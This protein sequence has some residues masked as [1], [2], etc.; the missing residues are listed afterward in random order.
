MEKPTMIDLNNNKQ[1][2]ALTNSAATKGAE[3]NLKEIISEALG[4]FSEKFFEDFQASQGMEKKMKALLYVFFAKAGGVKSPI[5]VDEQFTS[6]RKEILPEFQVYSFVG[7]F[8]QP[9]LK[10]TRTELFREVCNFIKKTFED[11]HIRLLHTESQLVKE[12]QKHLSIEDIDPQSPAYYNWFVVSEAL[13]VLKF[14]QKGIN[15]DKPVLM[16]REGFQALM[17][18]LDAAYPEEDYTIPFVEGYLPQGGHTFDLDVRVAEPNNFRYF[19]E[20]MG[21]NDLSLIAEVFSKLNPKEKAKPIELKK[22][23]IHSG[24]VLVFDEDEKDKAISLIPDGYNDYIVKMPAGD[25]LQ[26][27]QVVTAANQSGMIPPQDMVSL[28]SVGALC[29][30]ILTYGTTTVGCRTKYDSKRNSSRDNKGF[31]HLGLD[32]FEVIKRILDK[33]DTVYEQ[34]SGSHRDDV[35]AFYFNDVLNWFPNP[36]FKED[37]GKL[38]FLDAVGEDGDLSKLNAYRAQ[39]GE[40]GTSWKYQ[41]TGVNKTQTVQ[42]LLNRGYIL[43]T[44]N[45]TALSSDILMV[46]GEDLTEDECSLLLDLLDKKGIKHI[47]SRVCG[48]QDVKAWKEEMVNY[49]G[50]LENL[51]K[52]VARHH[53]DDLVFLMSNKG[54]NKAID[55]LRNLFALVESPHAEVTS[56]LGWQFPKSKVEGNTGIAIG[57]IKTH[58]FTGIGDGTSLWMPNNKGEKQPI[59][60]IGD[61]E[62]RHDFS[63]PEEEYEADIPLIEVVQPRFAP[64]GEEEKD[65]ELNLLYNFDFDL[66]SKTAVGVEVS[67]GDT[68][69]HVCTEEVDYT[70]SSSQNGYLTQIKAYK[71]EDKGSPRFRV[72]AYYHTIETAFKG[73]GPLKMTLLDVNW[74]GRQNLLKLNHNREDITGQFV[75][76]GQCLK[77]TDIAYNRLL[78]FGCTLANGL[79]NY[80]NLSNSAKNIIKQMK[81]LAEEYNSK[82]GYEGIDNRVVVDPKGIINN[83]HKPLLD[84]VDKTFGGSIWFTPEIHHEHI[85]ALETTFRA[86]KDEKECVVVQDPQTSVPEVANKKDL[87]VL[88]NKE[89]P[90]EKS[91]VVAFYD[92]GGKR[93]YATRVYAYYGV[94][95]TPEFCLPTGIEKSTVKDAVGD[96]SLTPSVIRNLPE[97]LAEEMTFDSKRK[98]QVF[99]L[100]SA[101]DRA[102]KCLNLRQAKE[103]AAFDLNEEPIK[104]L[105]VADFQP[106]DKDPGDGDVLF[107]AIADKIE[108]ED[109][110]G[111]VYVDP[112][113]TKNLI[114]DLAKDPEVGATILALPAN[115]KKGRCYLSLL[116]INE[117]DANKTEEA[118]D[119]IGSLVKEYLLKFAGDEEDPKSDHLKGLATRIK[120][121]LDNYVEGSSFQK[122]PFK[123]AKVANTKPVVGPDCAPHEAHILVDET[124]GSFWKESWVK[125]LN[126][127]RHTLTK[128][129][130]LEAA[131]EIRKYL[132]EPYP[133]VVKM[134]RNPLGHAPTMKLYPV[135]QR[136][137][138]Q[139]KLNED[140]SY[141][142][143][144]YEL[145]PYQFK[146]SYEGITRTCGDA[147]GDLLALIW[148]HHYREELELLTQD[149]LFSFLAEVSGT[150]PLRDVD[151]GDYWMDYTEMKGELPSTD[152]VTGISGSFKEDF[153]IET[154]RTQQ[155]WTTG[156][157]LCYALWNF[158]QQMVN[159]VSVLEDL[160]SFQESV[161]LG[162]NALAAK[163]VASE[164]YEQQLSNYEYPAYYLSVKMLRDL[165]FNPE[166][167]HDQQ[168]VRDILPDIGVN[169]KYGYHYHS[170]ADCYYL[171]RSIFDGKTSIKEVIDD[172]KGHNRQ[173]LLL[174]LMA[175][176]SQMAQ[177]GKLQL[178]YFK[179]GIRVTKRAGK[180]VEP[181]HITAIHNI[182]GWS[183]R[184][185]KADELGY[186]PSL[187]RSFSFRWMRDIAQSCE[188]AFS[189][190]APDIDFSPFSFEE[191]EE[192]AEAIEEEEVEEEKGD[193]IDELIVK[194]KAEL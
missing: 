135:F 143:L 96:T 181:P 124:A 60:G 16:S 167:Q 56:P 91:W 140:G 119:G 187:E 27:I 80:D 114:E 47:Y 116:A 155:Q 163:D 120:K 169:P 170:A 48:D 191:E 157:G 41:V 90:D 10:G 1:L 158:I 32:I 75:I 85:N 73:R 136:E 59:V 171:A 101:C 164:I 129:G 95:G 7:D 133:V 193:E 23:L 182:A 68:I 190:D 78:D 2:A 180:E 185:G 108:E 148:A 71:T 22:S 81:L 86:R 69:A 159:Q 105:D 8:Q 58:T 131:N 34:S 184:G 162:W 176:F 149:E 63:C 123:G 43:S 18:I 107:A 28:S 4:E 67:K 12:V 110:D 192:D 178:G 113:K 15:N 61:K 142:K 141:T 72:V 177:Q 104:V 154:I 160:K 50:S 17:E 100:L 53:K 153:L 179:N 122:L 24:Y 138:G 103:E 146:S 55:R 121:A 20:G 82:I 42:E 102:N 89:K 33:E 137:D 13:Q 147:D 79:A 173:T 109:V 188:L 99:N 172:P 150:D 37:K 40:Y 51:H 94:E 97:G 38:K 76:T 65:G 14:W 45:N 70:V 6:L 52:A 11:F 93:V 156:V 127:L 186:I 126:R 44:K 161:D 92:E 29:Y 132:K 88:S 145:N 189:G 19:Y 125:H 151:Y 84:F 62:S 54:G 152:K 165:M 36:H 25:E 106:E 112:E 174:M 118:T 21:I 74:E 87:L 98:C 26:P 35:Q 111:E 66:G 31:K 139:Y 83:Y 175:V 57:A 117:L 128:M 130:R 166:P 183:Q 77:A 9:K 46:K 49:H 30:Y 134:N 144:N 3:E 5:G 115:T 39:I 168:N 64:D 194:L